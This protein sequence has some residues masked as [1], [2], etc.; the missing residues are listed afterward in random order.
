[1]DH[2]A[3]IN[4]TLQSQHYLSLQKKTIFWRKRFYLKV[5]DPNTFDNCNKQRH[6][7]ASTSILSWQSINLSKSFRIVSGWFEFFL[8]IQGFLG[9]VGASKWTIWK[10]LLALL[11][12]PTI[13]KKTTGRGLKV[14]SCH[15]VSRSFRLS[16]AVFQSFLFVEVST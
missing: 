13:L 10:A 2:L 14:N 11:Y 9:R 3:Q 7:V 15:D 12:V 1:M 16:T 8:G 5:F 4:L 6:V